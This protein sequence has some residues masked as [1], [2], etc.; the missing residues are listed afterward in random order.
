MSNDKIN[1]TKRVILNC[2]Q[3]LIEIIEH[4]HNRGLVNKLRTQQRLLEGLDERIERS[5]LPD[6]FVRSIINDI[7]LDVLMIYSEIKLLIT[8]RKQ[9]VAAPTAK[10]KQQAHD[11]LAEYSGETSEFVNTGNAFGTDQLSEIELLLNRLKDIEHR[12]HE[13]LL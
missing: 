1:S 6:G 5:Q 9:E 8:L 7:R 13:S 12:L 2:I 4:E 3:E 10:L 11:R